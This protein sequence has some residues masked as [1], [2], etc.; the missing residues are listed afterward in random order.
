MLSG[1]ASP[2]RGWP[3]GCFLFRVRAGSGCIACG[4]EED[5]LMTG[6][7]SWLTLLPLVPFLLV[8]GSYWLFT[9]RWFR[10]MHH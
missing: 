1:P 9:E 10:H 4:R 8:L 5:A 2:G 6:E 7:A 3:A